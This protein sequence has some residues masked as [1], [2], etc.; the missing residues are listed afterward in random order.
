MKGHACAVVGGQLGS[1]GK[2]AL[3]KAIAGQFQSHV[4][5]GGPNAGHSMFYGGKLFKM[6]QLPCGWVNATAKQYI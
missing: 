3:V 5:V 2:G 6:Q 4:R 1:E